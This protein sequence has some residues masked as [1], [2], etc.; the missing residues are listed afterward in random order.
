MTTTNHSFTSSGLTSIMVLDFS[1]STLLSRRRLV[2][3]HL[4]YRVGA[5][6]TYEYSV[7]RVP[8]I[9]RNDKGEQESDDKDLKG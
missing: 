6:S 1:S 9:G 2:P 3:P 7:G 4:H 5:T 8:G